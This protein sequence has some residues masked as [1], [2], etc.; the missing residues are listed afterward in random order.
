M[1]F[2]RITFNSNPPKGHYVY[3]PFFRNTKAKEEKM[4]PLTFNLTKLANRILSER[5]SCERAHF[6]LSEYIVFICVPIC[7]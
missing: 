2:G 4:W 6:Y 1:N 3:P 7:S 5:C